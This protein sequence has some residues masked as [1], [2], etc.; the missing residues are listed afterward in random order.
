[1]V[2]CWKKIGGIYSVL[3]PMN[4]MS[5]EREGLTFRTGQ[6]VGHEC[7]GFGMHL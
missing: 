6:Y 5:G 4:K 3:N 1:M 7:I 2:R